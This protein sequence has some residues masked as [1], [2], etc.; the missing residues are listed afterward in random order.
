M[1]RLIA[2]YL[3]DALYLARCSA[4]RVETEEYTKDSYDASK[5]KG[6]GLNILK[7]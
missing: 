2:N 5:L 7:K 3:P 6:K 4:S 1:Y